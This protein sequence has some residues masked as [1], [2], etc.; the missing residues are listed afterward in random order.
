MY[1]YPEDLRSGDV[2]FDHIIKE[3]MIDYCSSRD[4][5]FKMM[6]GMTWCLKKNILVE[7]QGKVE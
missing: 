4:Y 1:K 3:R 2:I 7:V 5:H 6:S